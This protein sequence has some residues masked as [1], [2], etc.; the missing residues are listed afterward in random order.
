MH[1]FYSHVLALLKYFMVN[2]QYVTIISYCGQE[3]KDKKKTLIRNE[4]VKKDNG[5]QKA[6]SLC[7]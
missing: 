6:K 2:N 7:F 1:L 4:L 5:Q 3:L